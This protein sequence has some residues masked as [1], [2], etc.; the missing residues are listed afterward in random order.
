MPKVKKPTINLVLRKEKRMKDGLYPIFIRV[1]FQGVLERATGY[2]CDIEHWDNDNQCIRRGFP[3]YKNINNDLI[4]IK[5]GAISEMERQR[6]DGKG[7]DKAS[8]LRSDG[9][10][11]GDVDN[12]PAR[13]FSG[14]VA[15]YLRSHSLTKTTQHTW[16]TVKNH[17]I[18][19]FGDSLERWDI[20]EFVAYCGR[21]KLSD[22]SMALMI[23]K[24]RA[25]KLPT[26]NINMRRWKCA[27]RNAYVNSRSMV[28]IKRKLLDIMCD[29]NGMYRKEFLRLFRQSYATKKEFALYY[30]YFMYMTGLAEVD[31]AFLEKKQIDTKTINGVLYYIITGKRHK[32]GMAYKIPIKGTDDVRFIIDVMMTYNNGTRFFLPICKGLTPDDTDKCIQRERNV[33]ERC[34]NKLEELILDINLEIATNNV[35][36]GDN[37]PLIDPHITYYAFRHSTA[38]A[39]FNAPN[40]TM[41]QMAQ[42]MGR[43]PSNIQTYIHQLGED[44]D[45]E[46]MGNLV[47]F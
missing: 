36:N 2:A 11:G 14:L 31:M 23:G 30:A 41:A 24:I 42:Y 44:S 35:D 26:K 38:M 8:I 1:S 33:F 9:L 43:L 25:L 16:R 19:C 47:E 28:F 4:R 6:L 12:Y 32:T 15:A 17:L 22:S 10:S 34:R 5:S 3:N 45:L 7:F 27:Y 46:Q 13:S 20:D 21:R 37:V 40:T 29:D 39:L 18:A